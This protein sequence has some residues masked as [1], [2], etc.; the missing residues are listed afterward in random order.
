MSYVLSTGTEL[1]LKD[2]LRSEA[3]RLICGRWLDDILSEMTGHAVSRS[4]EIICSD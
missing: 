2:D 4:I 3:Y 1:G